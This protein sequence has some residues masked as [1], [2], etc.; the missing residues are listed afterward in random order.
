MVEINLAQDY[1]MSLKEIGERYLH[2]FKKRSHTLPLHIQIACGLLS[3]PQLEDILR[4]KPYL[5][6]VRDDCGRVPLMV[7]YHSV[8]SILLKYGAD[9]NAKDDYGNTVLMYHRKH[10]EAIEELVKAGADINATNNAGVSMTMMTLLG[11]GLVKPLLDLGATL[12]REVP[13]D[14]ADFAFLCRL[15]QEP[16]DVLEKIF[17][18]CSPSEEAYL[19]AK[20]RLGSLDQQKYEWLKS[21]GH[22]YSGKKVKAFDKHEEERFLWVL[23]SRARSNDFHEVE[24]LISNMDECFEDRSSFINCIRKS[25][26]ILNGVHNPDSLEFLLKAGADPNLGKKWRDDTDE[27]TL[28]YRAVCDHDCRAVKLLLD[29]GADPNTGTTY[30]DSDDTCVVRAISDNELEI[31]RMLIDAKANMDFAIRCDR[32]PVITAIRCDNLPA[33]KMVIDAGATPCLADQFGRV[34]E[35]YLSDRNSPVLSKYFKSVLCQG[36]QKNKESTHD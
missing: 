32:T 13:R 15:L 2:F 36:S 29:H 9:P 16:L 18:L 31:L 1:A 30:M 22:L 35:D 28:L 26:T 7:D 34:P 25:K 3:F 10:R 14:K 27:G 21:K 11:D 17:D 4:K 12:P 8:Y 20:I 5:A 23:G 19:H 33:L 24:Q 6:N